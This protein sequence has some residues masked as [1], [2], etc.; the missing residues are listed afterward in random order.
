MVSTTQ[1]ENGVSRWLDKELMPK[2]PTGGAYDGLKKATTVAL[3]LYAIKRAKAAL[4]N[5]ARSEFMGTIGATDAAGNIDIEGYA[6]ELKK[7]MP[8]N[9]LHMNVPM[10]GE[11]TFYRSDIDDMLRYI[12]S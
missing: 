5:L 10:I 12:K 8:E 3:A 9:G 6:E 7:Q 4:D 1:I 2:L 11:L